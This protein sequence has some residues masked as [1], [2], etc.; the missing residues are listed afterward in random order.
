MEAQ[1][2]ANGMS[3]APC[4]GKERATSHVGASVNV[5]SVS[6]ACAST[7]ITQKA[8]QPNLRRLVIVHFIDLSL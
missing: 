5:L 3:C 2:M 1:V 7:T 8:S 4:F 6:G